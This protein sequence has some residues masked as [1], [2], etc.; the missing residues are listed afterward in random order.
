[1][2]KKEGARKG[3]ST[4]GSR[5]G[6]SNS[7]NGQ[8]GK[9][10]GDCGHGRTKKR[11][12]GRGGGR[13]G[14]QA[15]SQYGTRSKEDRAAFQKE[16]KAKIATDLKNLSDHKKE[17]RVPL[18]NSVSH[19]K[20][21]LSGEIETVK[22]LD[23]RWIGDLSFF[24]YLPS[25]NSSLQSL[26]TLKYLNNDLRELLLA[27]YHVFWSYV[28]LDK[29]FSLFLDSFLRYFDE[30]SLPLP[31]LQ[32]AELGSLDAAGLKGALFQRVFLVVCRMSQME[33]APHLFISSSFYTQEVAKNHLLDLPKLIDFTRL[34]GCHNRQKVA[35]TLKFLFYQLPRL[36]KDFKTALAVVAEELDRAGAAAFDESGTTDMQGV[37]TALVDLTFTTATFVDIAPNCTA[38]ALR[39]NQQFVNLLFYTHDATAARLERLLP[40]EAF[41]GKMLKLR[42]SIQS[43]VYAVLE[44]CYLGHLLL[45]REKRDFSPE[46]AAQAV[47]DLVCG[48]QQVVTSFATLKGH[49]HP[50]AL[51]SL[52]AALENAHALSSGLRK[53]AGVVPTR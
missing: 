7:N 32:R 5:S 23:R 18:E 34:Y 22:D 14:A 11:Q 15:T 3:K 38:Y 52:L 26:E 10:S 1:M 50:T 31:D 2:A 12:G 42:R 20:D 19:V 36:K 8:R 27:P 39:D 16:R 43:L 6:A 49:P 29:S 4:E 33:E 21:E 48:S 25:D 9:S 40:A 47:A 30:P 51:G 17:E 13:G 28:L 37:L 45:G 46:E 41:A 53:A 44:R 35:S 24:E